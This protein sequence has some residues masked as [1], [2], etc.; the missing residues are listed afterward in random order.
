MGAFTLSRLIWR[1]AARRPRAIL[2]TIMLALSAGFLVLPDPG[3]GYA[4]LTLRERPL[5]YTPAVMGFITGGEFTAF[6]GALGVLAMT[7]M[8][9]L[10]A[11]RTVY[12][13]TAAPAWRLALGAWIAAF[14]VGL[15][16]LT[17]I[18]AGALVR[19][20]QVIEQAGD[21]ATGLW[22]FASWTYGLGVVGAGLSATVYA[23]LSLRLATRPGLFMGAAFLAWI[24]ILSLAISK[25][26]D[27]SGEHFASPHLFPGVR[28]PDLSMGII[29]GAHR[30]GAVVT[31]PLGD[32]LATPGGAGFLAS[33]LALVLAGLALTLLLSGPQVKPVVARSRG[34]A[35]PLHAL[36]SA[37]AARLGLAGVVFRQVWT[38]S[39]STLVV[40][41]VAVSVEAWHGNDPL[42]VIALGFAWGLYMLRW[43]EL[44]AAFEQGA[45]RSLVAPS[46]LGPWPVRAQLLGQ[47]A[48]QLA[49]LAL[50]LALTFASAS[51]T[52]ALSWLAVQV[53]VAPILCVGLARLPGG[54]TLFSLGA[55]V[56]WYLLV[57]GNLRA[58]FG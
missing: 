7:V 6:S 19:A 11:W 18:W 33:R 26:V 52:G 10:A 3:A 8:A 24:L 51:R 14:A 39:P 58:P 1:E 2:A 56:W 28:S 17:C 46:V 31:H 48:V 54:A 23:V 32:L 55:M 34:G 36:A 22:V 45:L 29:V 47:I 42:G 9:P 43:P 4:T 44:C 15:F 16:L 35:W 38:A 41:A 5:A 50:P 13:V 25:G 40:L 21:V 37:I 57:S 49:V 30:Q 53:A 20:W 27:L 12:G